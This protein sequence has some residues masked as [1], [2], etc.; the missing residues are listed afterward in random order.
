MDTEFF[1]SHFFYR[2]ATKAGLMYHLRTFV[3]I[4]LISVTT[5]MP[6]VA[7]WVGSFHSFSEDR[8][9]QE[10]TIS[11]VELEN[12]PSPRQAVQSD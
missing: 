3:Y 12:S 4:V 11:T 7:T 2:A 9:D 1:Y 10:Y 8:V 5:S 6:T